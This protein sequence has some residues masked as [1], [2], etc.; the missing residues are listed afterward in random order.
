MISNL[1]INK[2]LYEEYGIAFIFTLKIQKKTN[3]KKNL[4]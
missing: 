1:I 2:V 4:V 3:N